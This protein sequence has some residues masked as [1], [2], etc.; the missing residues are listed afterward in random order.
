MLQSDDWAPLTIVRG[1]FDD[2]TWRRRLAAV[3][4]PDG[5]TVLNPTTR[6][7]WI[8][9]GDTFRRVRPMLLR[10]YAGRWHVHCQVPGCGYR[11]HSRIA[12]STAYT[13]AV[14]HLGLHRSA[15][16]LTDARVH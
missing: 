5:C 6:E 10:W 13:H 1:W 9:S 14:R 11:S 15:D 16:C 3:G 2:A 7:L 12:L 4:L 8:R